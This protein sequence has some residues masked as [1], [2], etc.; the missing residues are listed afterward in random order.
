MHRFNSESAGNEFK[1]LCIEVL[2]AIE[3]IEK[4]LE[5]AGVTE[6]ADVRI[7]KNGY[8][9]FEIYDSE[10]RMAR[11]EKEGA[12]KIIY[13]HSEEISVPD[14]RGFDK[15]SENLVEILLAFAS[16]QPELGDRQEID[17]V[18]WKQEFVAWANEFENMYKNVYWGTDETDGR[19]Y[20][21]VIE[22]FAKKKIRKFAG[23]EG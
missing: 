17:S 14:G 19:D 20:L 15:V 11:Y 4:A 22:E 13:E 7:G 6:S 10:W 8:L 18:V 1:D 16:L 5:K 3:N 23:L 9:A 2:P 21:E 12:V